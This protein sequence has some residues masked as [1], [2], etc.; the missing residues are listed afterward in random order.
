MEPTE[1]I[2]AKRRQLI[3]ALLAI[4]RGAGHVII[5]MDLAAALERAWVEYD[6]MM[7]L[8]ANQEVER[9]RAVIQVVN[10][11]AWQDDDDTNGAL[12][13]IARLTDVA[14]GKP[15]ST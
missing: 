4:H 14:L 3:D 5:D 11:Q 8:S 10:T 1:E 15:K 12:R 7:A 6:A 13:R 9:L 2:K